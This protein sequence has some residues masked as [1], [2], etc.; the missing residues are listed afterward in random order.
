MAASNDNIEREIGEERRALIRNLE[1]QHQLLKRIGEERQKTL[2]QLEEEKKEAR[3]QQ[4][5]KAEAAVRKRRQEEDEERFLW[6]RPNFK[7]KPLDGPFIM[8][9]GTRFYL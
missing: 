9:D 4:I 3:R 7:V 8:E 2:Q 5:K 6:L 1:Q